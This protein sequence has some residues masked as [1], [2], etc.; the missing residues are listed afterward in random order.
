MPWDD[1]LYGNSRII[2]SSQS[3]VIRVM[4]GPGT[5]KSF[6]LQRRVQRL[7]ESGTQPERIL[8]V[9][10]T[11]NAA[12]N[13]IN[14]LNS[15][16]VEGA[17]RIKASTLHSFAL[18]ILKNNQVFRYTNRNPRPLIGINSNGVMKF[19]YYPMILDIIKTDIE[20]QF[21]SPKE[22][23]KKI[24]AFE[25]AWATLQNE[26]A[27]WPQNPIDRALN[28]K[29]IDWLIFHKGMTIGELIP[30]CL[31]YLRNNPINPIISQFEHILVDEYQDLNKAEQT[32]INI[33][34]NNNNLIIV[35]D[36]DQSIYSFRHAHPE[37]IVQFID[38]FPETDDISLCECRRCPVSI[39]EIA[40]NFI[41][42][43]YGTFVD[44]ILIPF[45]GN[46]NGEINI[47]QWNNLEEE[48][49]SIAQYC[50]YLIR[51]SFELK[52]ILILTP[53]REIA[54]RIKDYLNILELPSHNYYHDNIIKS[55]EVQQK[56]SFLSLLCNNNDRISL[57]FLLGVNHSNCHS[58]NYKELMIYC[59][60]NSKEPYEALLE[61]VEN[62][63]EVNS[64]LRKL[65]PIFTLINSKINDLNTMEFSEVINDL[66]PSNNPD[67]SE[68]RQLLDKPNID[69]LNKAYNE[70]I[71]YLAHPETPDSGDF[72]SIMSIHKSKGLTKKIVILSTCNQGLTPMNCSDDHSLQE[73]RRLFYVA[74]TR[75]RKKLLISS[76]ANIDYATARRLNMQV[77]GNRAQT[78][79]FIDELG[80]NAPRVQIGNQW[81]SQI[82]RQG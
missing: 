42:N 32:L 60:E 50:S 33:L 2:A 71:N 23:T 14:D 7:L 1:E 64:K 68:I 30:L 25:A 46:D 82:V 37:G 40:N 34:S 53:R 11:R 8:A 70:I 31:T 59:I 18:N 74:L 43:N 75:C 29:I 19:E 28:D 52:D 67:L 61:I 35:G 15:L 56:L 63:I 5:G 77:N 76:I 4:A 21:G 38:E 79:Q 45:E 13:L 65:K 41:Q 20:H 62:N 16:H 66:F 26:E 3:Q 22:I 44:P 55:E 78:S 6:A 57:R 54:N 10:F 72:I 73:Q 69:T 17:S 81:L 9:T 36:R 27:G 51:D 39:V 24:R 48:A 80:R 12:Q 47:V 49:Q 58:N